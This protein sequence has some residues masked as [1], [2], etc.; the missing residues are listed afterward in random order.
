MEQNLIENLTKLTNVSE[1][2]LLKFIPLSE[3]VIGHAVHESMC[4]NKDVTI[5]D[6]GIGNIHIRV[7]HDEV[8][9]KFVPSK[10][11]SDMLEKTVVTGISPLVSK[12]SEDIQEKINRSYR[13]LL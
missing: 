5:I 4:L 3:C 2:T 8:R 12:L 13:E 7:A 10:D 11:L 1:K 6:I 9:Y